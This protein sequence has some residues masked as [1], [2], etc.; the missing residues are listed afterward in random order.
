MIYSDKIKLDHTEYIDPCVCSA[1]VA[2]AVI[3]AGVLGAGATIYSANKA[4][5]TQQKAAAQ[6]AAVQQQMYQ[7]TRSDLSPYRDIGGVASKELTGKLTDLTTPISVNPQDFLGS[8]YYKFLEQQGMKGV[9]NSFAARGLAKAG[10]AL[11][12]SAAFLK[13]LNSQEWINNFNMQTTNQSNIFNRLKAL[14]DTGANAAAMTGQAGTSSA[15][16]QSSALIGGG[17]A[18]AAGINAAGGAVSNLANNIGGYAMYKGLY[19]GGNGPITLGGPNGP[20]PFT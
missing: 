1:W 13:G 10:A 3:G 18:A 6:A 20:T 19:G 2:T 7:Q 14:T 4:S 17:N 16:G 12:G 9:Q 8:D 11:K 5:D 15:A